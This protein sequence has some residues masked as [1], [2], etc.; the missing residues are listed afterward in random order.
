MR[1]RSRAGR[2]APRSRSAWDTMD[3]SPWW[4]PLEGTERSFS[5][6]PLGGPPKNASSC[7]L[8]YAQPF[9]NRLQRTKKEL[10]IAIECTE[11]SLRSPAIPKERRIE[12]DD[13]AYE[14]LDKSSPRQR[15]VTRAGLVDR[16]GRV[17]DV[18]LQARARRQILIEGGLHSVVSRIGVFNEKY[19]NAKDQAQTQKGSSLARLLRTRAM[20]RLWGLLSLLYELARV[21]VRDAEAAPG[22]TESTLRR[23]SRLGVPASSIPDLLK[24]AGLPRM[25]VPQVKNLLIRKRV[26]PPSR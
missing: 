2:A 22:G 19:Q 10:A 7:E 25:T 24:L 26:L 20:S 17:L 16:R 5:G 23:L 14:I 4:P 1:R 11:Q 8:R 21:A 3:A 18:L 15:K 12:L 13:C 6:P 9:L